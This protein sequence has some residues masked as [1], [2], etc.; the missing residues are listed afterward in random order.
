M[1]T[2]KLEAVRKTR[3]ALRAHRRKGQEVIE[4]TLIMLPLFGITFLT[5]DIAWAIF[6]KA[7]L[8]WAVRDAVRYGVTVTAAQ[9]GAGG[10]TT[11]VKLKA[12]QLSLGLLSGTSGA[13]NTDSHLQV[14]FYEPNATT[15]V[16]DVTADAGANDPGNILQLSV[17]SYQMFKLLP[18]FYSWNQAPDTGKIT[19]SVAS[20]D[21]IEYSNDVPAEGPAP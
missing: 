19:I 15:G 6:S 21:I 11:A 17:N 18:L 16:T 9:A 1:T 7:T 20:A 5:L 13:D 12:A 10:L 3:R 8:Q 4:F 2:T 14:H